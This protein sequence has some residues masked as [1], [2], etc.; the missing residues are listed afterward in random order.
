MIITGYMAAKC[1]HLWFCK[2]VVSVILLQF[3]WSLLMFLLLKQG[4]S[5][6]YETNV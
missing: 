3:L 2:L 1:E 4:A 6:A 5:E